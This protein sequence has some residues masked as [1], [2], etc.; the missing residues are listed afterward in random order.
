[1]RSAAVRP[2]GA[3]VRMVNQQPYL[4]GEWSFFRAET[5]SRASPPEGVVFEE[6]TPRDR[7]PRGRRSVA[8]ASTRGMSAHDGATPLAQDL[9]RALG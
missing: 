4:V 2:G 6:P 5:P 1:M 3:L 8:E 9:P 7:S